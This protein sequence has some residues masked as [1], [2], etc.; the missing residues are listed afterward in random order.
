MGKKKNYTD[1]RDLTETAVVASSGTASGVI[2]TNG[3]SL[4]GLVM[5]AVFTGTALAFQASE[6][7]TG[8]FAAVHDSSGAIALTV[9]AATIILFDTDLLKSVRYLK[10]IVDA[11]AAERTFGLILA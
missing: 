10:L 11:Q 9:A 2:D 3:L 5:P 4:V 7:K 6:T 1:E 8:T